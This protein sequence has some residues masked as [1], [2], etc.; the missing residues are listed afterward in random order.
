MLISASIRIGDPLQSAQHSASQK[1][2]DFADPDDPGGLWNMYLR[3]ADIED[4]S[5]I[6]RWKA[7]TDGILIFVS[8]HNY[9]HFP[10]GSDSK[11]KVGFILRCPRDV[12][13]SVNSRRPT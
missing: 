3:V 7:D 4:E 6:G 8:A 11:K 13:G 1:W 2:P 10:N 9:T 5:V 12:G